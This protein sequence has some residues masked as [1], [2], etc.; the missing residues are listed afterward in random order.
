MANYY[1]QAILASK[2][3]N[4]EDVNTNIFAGTHAGVIT[5]SQY[6][7]WRTAVIEFYNQVEING[8]CQGRAQTGHVIK[9]YATT[10]TTPNY[11]IYESAFQLTNDPGGIDL[12]AE[13]SLCV[14]YA[15]DSLSLIP[16]GRRRG[17]IYISEWPEGANA[18]GRPDNT[19]SDVLCL[20]YKEYADDTNAVT[21]LTAGVWSRKNSTVY[22]IERVWCDNEWDTMRSRGGKSTYRKTLSV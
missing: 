6:E 21:D 22:A 12:P 18:D 17:R 8:G 10:G 3:G 2:T 1:I 5:Q 16:R 15:N 20:K 14:S 13:V 4:T 19:V 11:P 7:D 9:M